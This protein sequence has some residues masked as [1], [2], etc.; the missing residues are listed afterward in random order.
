MP[1]HRCEIALSASLGSWKISGAF[2]RASLIS[3]W[4]H[5]SELSLLVVCF[6]ISLETPTCVI[7]NLIDVMQMRI[8]CPRFKGKQL[9]CPVTMCRVNYTQE[10]W[11]EHATTL[12]THCSFL[13]NVRTH[14]QPTRLPKTST[15]KSQLPWTA[16]FCTAPTASH[17]QPKQKGP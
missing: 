14:W 7:S 9:P 3:T 8:T 17:S 5:K 11:M 1:T 6:T 15:E 2:W 10:A 12:P 13:D 4:L 16:L